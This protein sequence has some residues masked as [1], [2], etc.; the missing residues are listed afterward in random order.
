MGGVVEERLSYTANDCNTGRNTMHFRGGWK[1]E[2]L[3]S[4][5]EREVQTSYTCTAVEDGGSFRFLLELFACCEGGE[6]DLGSLH[7]RDQKTF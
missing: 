2:L 3:G 4:V 6:A 1:T 5:I 7:S